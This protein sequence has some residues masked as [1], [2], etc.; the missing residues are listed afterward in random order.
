MTEAV[1]LTM[2]MLLV[3]IGSAA[4]IALIDPKFMRWLCARGLGWAAAFECFRP[5]RAEVTEAWERKLGI[6]KETQRQLLIGRED[7]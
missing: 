1:N 3:A 5:N 4:A 7:A 6:D 2:A